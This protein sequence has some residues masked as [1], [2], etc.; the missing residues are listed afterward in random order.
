MNARAPAIP[1]DGVLLWEPQPR[2]AMF[3]RCPASEVMYGGSRGGGKT[4]GIL[5]DWLEHSHVH[6]KYARGL[7]VRRRLVQLEEMIERGKELYLPIG[8][9]WHEQKKHFQMPSGSILR[10]RYLESDD[11]AQ[12]YQGHS[13]TRLYPEELTNFPSPTPIYRLQATL[14]SANGINCQMKSTCNPGGPGH[15]WVKNR[16]IDPAPPFTPYSDDGGKTFRVFIPAQLADNPALLDHDPGY[17]DR[18]K[19]VG[20]P[21]LVRAWLEGDWNVALGAFFPEFNVMRHVIPT[22]PIPADWN[23]LYR[24]MDWGSYRP[25]AVVWFAVASGSTPSS[26]PFPIP[27]GALVAYRELYGWNGVPNEGHKPP[28]PARDVARMILDVEADDHDLLTKS[29]CKLDPACWSTN[30]G[31]SIAETMAREDVWFNPADNKR[32][33]R[34]GSFGGWDQVRARLV[35]EDNPMI[36]FMDNCRHAIRT[37]PSVPRDPIILDDVDTESE[38]HMPDAIR[39]GCMARPYA[40]TIPEPKPMVSPSGAWMS[41]FRLDDLW[42]YAPAVDVRPS[43]A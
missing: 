38:D 9:Q 10:M 42:Q 27:R 5:G 22:A 3:I 18:L 8:S 13:Y 35:G 30:G 29:L 19:K 43:R 1:A 6:G 25:F 28:L 33:S 21:E 15:L 20:D 26:W 14:R 24:A 34:R 11:D 40:P 41:N 7:A 36:Y 4:D 16:Y 12:H 17:V 39:Y 32:T 23:I 37:I 2:Q 31:P